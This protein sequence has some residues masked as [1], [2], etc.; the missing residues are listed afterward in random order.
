MSDDLSKLHIDK[1]RIDVH[2]GKRRRYFLLALA[3][4]ILAGAGLLFS[5]G[6]LTP[7]VD[8]QVTSVQEIYPSQTFTLLNASGYVVAQRKAA[9][10]SK[11]TSR[12]VSMTVEEGSE[13]KEG[14]VIARLEN[15]DVLATKARAVADVSLARYNLQQARIEL[16]DAIRA[17]KRKE[18]VVGKGYV[19]QLERDAAE[20]RYRKAEAAAAGA[21]AAVLASE[22]AL[23][24]AEAN[25]DYA[26][27]RAPFDAVVLTK[28]ADVGDIVTPLGAAANAKASV[29]TIADLDSLQVEADV[30]ESNIGQ[31]A[32][33]QPCEVELDALPGKRFRGRVHMIVPTADRSKASIMVKV[34]FVEKDSRILPEMS[35]R[36]AFL[37]R[38]VSQEERKLMRA[39][40]ESALIEKDGKPK[41]FVVR[42]NRVAE[43]DVQPGRRFGEVMEILGGL[44]IGDKVVVSPNRIEDGDR[45]SIPQ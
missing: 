10:A 20:A 8:V 44:D 32:V 35:A 13:V 22:A 5:R 36:V 37:S 14:E 31:V 3:L 42:S 9:V 41:V 6:V 40:P 17:Y 25:V 24:E 27:I 15:A 43:A 18:E 33:G 21:E 30:S 38:E 4:L 39:I 12:L 34:A 45:V 19:S 26:N 2:G 23:R 7:A 1:R 29:V 11:I 16:E 28:D